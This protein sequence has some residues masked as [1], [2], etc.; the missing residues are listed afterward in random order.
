MISSAILSLS[1]SRDGQLHL[2]YP[3]QSGQENFEIAYWLWADGRW[4]IAEGTELLGNF[5]FQHGAVSNDVGSDNRLGIIIVAD[6]T[7]SLPDT[8]I[9]ENMIFSERVVKLGEDIMAEE[10][11]AEMPSDT[12]IPTA[13]T[14]IINPTAAT[15]TQSISENALL[16]LPSSD[17]GN[18][19]SG[20]IIAIILVS[21]IVGGLSIMYILFVRNRSQH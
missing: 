3:F 6:S 14:G 18:S 10:P 15:P 5:D 20:I 8:P 4:T 1:A 12:Q 13:T 16:E 2:N 21:V 17:R 11:I 7:A 9:Q 19:W